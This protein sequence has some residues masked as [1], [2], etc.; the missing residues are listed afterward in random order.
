MKPYK[1]RSKI[2]KGQ[3]GLT[4]IMGN[5]DRDEMLTYSDSKGN[6]VTKPNVKAGFVSGT[7]PV[8]EAYAVG[9]A[10]APAYK[11]V[12]DG[13]LYGLGRMGNTWARAKLIN[14]N[15]TI[16]PDMINFNV[17]KGSVDIQF[18]RKPWRNN[19]SNSNATMRIYP[20]GRKDKGYFELVKDNE[21]DMYS[22][23]FKTSKTAGSTTPTTYEERI[24][25]WEA[26]KDAIPEGSYVSTWGNLSNDGV[27]ALS[28]IGRGWIR[29]GNRNV[30]LKSGEPIT[31]PI[32]QKPYLIK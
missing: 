7:D 13:I 12:K 6:I 30:H 32:W 31:I 21:P 28:K 20:K 3:G 2:L 24:P 10:L 22:V 17:P 18:V 9:T 1:Y 5:P 8:G 29:A 26:L 15:M 27:R 25:L 4:L 23:H 19:P 14:R 11:V 16:D